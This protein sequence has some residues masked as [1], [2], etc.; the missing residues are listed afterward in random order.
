VTLARTGESRFI[1]DL[2]IKFACDFPKETEWTPT[3]V[4]I[5]DARGHCSSIASYTGHFPQS[6]DRILHELNNQLRQGQIEGAVIEW[7]PLC[8]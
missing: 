6:N 5:P 7:E 8:G 4:M 3:T 2:A 1:L